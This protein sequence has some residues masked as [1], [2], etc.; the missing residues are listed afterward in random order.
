MRIF[1]GLEEIANIAATYAKGFQALGHETYTVSRTNRFYPYP[2]YDVVVDER[3]GAS[4]L[5]TS[6]QKKIIARG[7]TQVILARE[8]L[9]A[10]HSCDT[11]IFI[12]ASSFLPR[13]IDYPILKSLKK[14]IISVFCGSDIRYWY[15]CEQDLSTLGMGSEFSE[16]FEYYA[17]TPRNIF[18]NKMAKVRVAERYSDLILSLP[19]YG[20]LQSR[21]YMRINIPIDLDQY[22]FRVPEREIPVVLHAPS[23]RSIK[24]TK[25]VLA[26][27]EQL[28]KEGIQ[29]NFKLIENMP[30]KQVREMLTNA[31]IVIDQ[32]FS[33]SVATL[34]LESMATGNV[35]L[36][37]Y[38]PE[39]VRL[40][41][42][43]P[44]IN[45]TPAKLANSLREAIL[46]QDLRRQ[47]AYAGRSYVETHHCHI[48]VT[49]QMI[50]YLE[51]GGI[52]EYDFV[53]TFFQNKFGMPDD[54]LKEERIML[55]KFWMRQIRK[56][57][58]R[59]S[60]KK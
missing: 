42:N 6:L 10:L 56:L 31:D 60:L 37:R 44:A 18:T 48:R 9:K 36:T 14:R 49:R 52:I 13:Y 20:Q 50:N 33:L 7:R 40:P 43:C 53:P 1:I 30:N 47:L 39:F 21:P 41:P 54:L 11:F 23:N 35:V 24:G 22:L 26:A 38:L 5:E 46:N 34:A 58:P 28:K 17:N 25:Y 2:E 29:F 32:L 59:L 57:F 8:F 19:S 4:H 45:V 15:A 55:W 3:F 51:P 16:L 12:Y 27:V